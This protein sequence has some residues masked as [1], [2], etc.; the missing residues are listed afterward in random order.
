M[1]IF[2]LDVNVLLALAW[3][4]HIHHEAAHIWFQE[5]GPSGWAT[6][7]LTQLGF[8]RLSMQ[9]A[10]VKVPLLFGDALAVLA[11][12]TAHSKHRFW[13]L[14]YG[15]AGIRDEI[16]VRIVGHRQLSDALFLDFAI[17]HKARLSTFDRRII[18][19]LPLGSEL[20]DSVATIPA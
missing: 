16:R 18:G 20:L 17:R 3:P 11:Q 10:V 4:N 1:S 5:H 8:L 12:S 7:T 15:V 13:P 9:P 6:C 14:D 2:L 19:L